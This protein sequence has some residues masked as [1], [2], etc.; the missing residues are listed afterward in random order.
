MDFNITIGMEGEA[1]ELVSQENTAKKYGSGGLEVYATPAM[2]GLMEN[3]S[4]KAVDPKLPEGFATVGINL[5]INH[6][7][8]TPIGM[9]VRAKA[10]LREVDKKKLTFYVQA[11]DE[12]EMIGEGT[13]SRYI[14]QVDKFLHRAQEKVNHNGV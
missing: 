5:E 2:V 11:F 6:L 1:Q 13:H 14:I 12:K 9:N 4:L 3:A 8:A 7:A 10:I